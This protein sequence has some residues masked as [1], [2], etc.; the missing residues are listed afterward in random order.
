[1]GKAGGRNTR[2]V[3]PDGYAA[4]SKREPLTY[5]EP[6]THYENAI[7]ALDGYGEKV[8]DAAALPAALDRALERVSGGQ[9]A[10]L[11]VVCGTG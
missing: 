1:M 5:F 6:G 11:N 10:L 2:D 3:D 9:Q 4:R 7:E 8:E